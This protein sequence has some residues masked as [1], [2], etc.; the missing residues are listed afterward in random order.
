MALADRLRTERLSKGMSPSALAEKAGISKAYVSQLEG[1]AQ[2]NP[3]LDVLK[4]I[5]DALGI[6]VGRLIGGD[7]AAPVVAERD[8][9]EPGLRDFLEDRRR[10][11]RV[12]PERDVQL[13]LNLQWRGGSRGGRPRTRDDWASFYEHI[14]PLWDRGRGGDDE[15]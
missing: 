4:R 8:P 3:S 6:T 5:S 12:V 15:P 9:P 14:L 10:R 11:G 7:V 1:G 13:L 2:E